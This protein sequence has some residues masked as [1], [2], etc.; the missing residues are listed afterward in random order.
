MSYPA[1]I[2]AFE[3]C[4]VNLANAALGRYDPIRIL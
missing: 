4:K 3:Q 1:V 2:E